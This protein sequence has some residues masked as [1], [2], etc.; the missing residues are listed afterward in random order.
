[1]DVITTLMCVVL[2]DLNLVGA[3]VFYVVD[4]PEKMLI[5]VKDRDIVALEFD[6]GFYIL[7]YMFS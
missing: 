2:N 4:I 3:E 5:C 7:L 6:N 1:M